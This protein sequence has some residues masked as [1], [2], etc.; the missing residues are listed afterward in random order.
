MRIK[1]ITYINIDDEAWTVAYGTT[2]PEALNQA[3][4]DV[5]DTIKAAF[6]DSPKWAEVGATVSDWSYVEPN[7]AG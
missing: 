4:G 2:R 7:P 6:N 1:A 3:V 5:H